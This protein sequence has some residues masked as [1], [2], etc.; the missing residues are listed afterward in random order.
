VLCLNKSAL[1]VVKFFLEGKW[2]VHDSERADG[3]FLHVKQFHICFLVLQRCLQLGLSAYIAALGLVTA[4]GSLRL[5]GK[6]G[7][8]VG[9]KFGLL[10]LV[11]TY[12]VIFSFDLVEGH[13]VVLLKIEWRV[14][15]HILQNIAY[16]SAVL[17][18]QAGAL[19]MRWRETELKTDVL[20]VFRLL[21][22]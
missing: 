21:F 7:T 19:E 20:D 18:W 14:R 4:A 6:L 9:H 10:R 17:Q 22:F 11:A 15:A 5:T 1:V 13:H 12:A 2:G 3:S 8:K 16:R